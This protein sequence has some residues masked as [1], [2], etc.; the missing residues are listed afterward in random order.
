MPKARVLIIDDSA[1]VRNI[2]RVILEKDRDIE[3]VGTAKD[4]I[5]AIAMIKE[6]KP[7]VLT[8]D[9]EMPKMDGLT[10]LD[11]LMK[12]VP[13]P[14]IVIS[15]KAHHGG[16]AS[17]QALDLGAI[18]YVTKPELSLE[19]GLMELE[20]TI[21]EKVK[22]AASIDRETLRRQYRITTGSADPLIADAPV[23]YSTDRLVAI[24]A[25]T[26]G[27]VAIRKILER[28]PGN[29]PPFLIAL[30][31]PAGFTASYA[32]G[33]NKLCRM[34]VK[35]A[36]DGELARQGFAYIAAGGRHLT[37]EKRDYQYVLRVEGGAA[38]NRHRP[39]IDK[40]FLSVAE[41]AGAQAIGIILTGM[42]ADGAHGL[43][44]MRKCGAM[45]IAQDEKSSIVF[46]MPK[47]AILMGAATQIVSLAD[48][49]Q[50][51]TDSL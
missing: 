21:V 18:D 22:F 23:V 35:E 10:F 49:P 43:K 6:K 13:L 39:S 5:Q 34:H 20:A 12:I 14:V 19:A 32:E 30:H 16:V 1:L 4:P 33:L 2:L 27:A 15:S 40:L 11:K 46:G 42:G 28:L 25:S 38:Y 24:G 44:E 31:M 3:V 7:N 37:V 48:I 50:V 29:F 8:L 36:E 17:L 47:Q 41:Y 9:L 26:G 51:I 45:T